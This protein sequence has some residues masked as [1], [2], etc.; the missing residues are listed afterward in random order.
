[1]GKDKTKQ[2]KRTKAHFYRML[3]TDGFL[4]F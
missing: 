3:L 1:M 2:F 4:P